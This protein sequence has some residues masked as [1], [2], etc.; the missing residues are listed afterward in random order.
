M[1]WSSHREPR[2][3]DVVAGLYRL[4]PPIGRGGY[5]TVY[6]AQRLDTAEH[7]ALKLLD[8]G[9]R[10]GRRRLDRFRREAALLRRLAHPGI[11]APL[12]A[13]M[14]NEGPFI[15]FELLLGETLA[16]R[17]DAGPLGVLDV[18]RIAL[19]ILDA[20]EAAHAVGIVHR[21][22]KPANVFLCETGRAAVKLLDFGIAKLMADE[23]GAATAMTAAGELT[24]T[25]A[26]VSPEHIG[27]APVDGRSDLFSLGL[28]MAEMLTGELPDADGDLIQ[29]AMS[30]LSPTPVTLPEMVRRSAIGH[31]VERALDKSVEHRYRSAAAMRR[32]LRDLLTTQPRVMVAAPATE[33]APW[34]PHQGGG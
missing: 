10:S 7:V 17:I 21:D 27:G 26:Y 5:A 33:R 28:I 34:T 8:G 15:A 14:A 12:A 16:D 2:Q 24:G 6:L 4:G 30:R 19:P 18:I 25:I 29:L 31:V 32:D 22:L 9:H 3:G 23:D 1:S 20:L 11:V 13:G